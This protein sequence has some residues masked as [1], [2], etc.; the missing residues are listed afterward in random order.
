ME[1]IV[2]GQRWAQALAV[3]AGGAE[4]AERFWQHT[5][6]LLSHSWAAGCAAPGPVQH[7]GVTWF[8]PVKPQ[9]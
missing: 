7:T 8:S 1:R 4:A 2:K 3:L 5:R 6:T 9:R